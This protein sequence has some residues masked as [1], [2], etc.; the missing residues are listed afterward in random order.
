M[1]CAN[2]LSFPTEERSQVELSC[3]SQALVKQ[4]LHFSAGERNIF[5][6]SCYCSLLK[7]SSHRLHK[8]LFAERGAAQEEDRY[9]HHEDFG[10]RSSKERRLG[11]CHLIPDTLVFDTG[12]RESGAS[13]CCMCVQFITHTCLASV[14]GALHM[15]CLFVWMQRLKPWCKTTSRTEVHLWAKHM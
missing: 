10:W 6:A 5:C 4:Q 2:P 7:T 1:I 13:M 8:P 11:I 14:P 12:H 15:I 9:H 3:F